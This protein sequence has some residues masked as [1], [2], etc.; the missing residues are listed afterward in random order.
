MKS[1]FN[2]LYILFLIFVLFLSSCGNDSSKQ[3]KISSVQTIIVND[4]SV[5]NTILTLFP[6]KITS[7]VNAKFS[8]N[9]NEEGVI[10]QCS[11]DG[12]NWYYCSSPVKYYR[13]NEKSHKFKVRAV[14]IAGNIDSTPSEYSWIID[15][16][17]P[18]TDI[19]IS[20]FPKYI[21]EDIIPINFSK[22]NTSVTYRCKIDDGEWYLCK[23]F[24]DVSLIS[25]GT[26][27]LEICAEDKLGNSDP[28]PKVIDFNIDRT[29]P[30]TIISSSKYISNS[31]DMYFQMISNEYPVVYKCQ[32][33]NNETENCNETISYSN[34]KEG[35]H[36]FK[37]WTTDLYGNTD[38]MPTEFNWIVDTVSPIITLLNYPDNITDFNNAVFSFT[39]TNEEVNFYAKID[40]D[41][42]REYPSV[43]TFNNIS[44]GEHLFYLYAIDKA[45]NSSEI[46]SYRWTVNE[47][48]MDTFILDTPVNPYNRTFAVFKFSSSIQNTDFECKFDTGIWEVCNSPKFY[49]Q[50]LEGEHNFQVRAIYQ[51]NIDTSPSQYTWIVDLTPPE[52]T[53]TGKPDNPSNSSSTEFIFSSNE[54]DSTFQCKLDSDNWSSCI[55]PKNYIGLGEGEH[56]FQ[57]KATDLAGNIDTSPSQYIWIVD[58]TPPDT[59]ITGTPDNLTNSTSADFTFSSNELDSTFQ[60]KL[61]SDN[62]SSCTS[63]KNYT[64]LN[65]GEHIFQ[66]R[67]IDIS[68]NIDTSP[69]QYTWIVDLTPPATT[70][71]S[72]PENPTNKTFGTVEFISSE[73]DSSFKCKLNADN[74]SSCTSPKNYVGLGEG[75]HVFQVKA[76]DLAG[77]TDNSPSQYTW[78][79][80][81]TPP[82]TAITG[83]PDNPT[84]STSADFLFSSNEV[85]SSFQCKL[86]SNNWS[87]CTSPKNY[88]GL[89]EGE[90][91]FQVKA[92]DLAGNTDPSPVQYTWTIDLTLPQVYIDSY[93]HNPTDYKTAVFQFHGSDDIEIS[94]FE[95]KL[96]NG[97]WSICDISENY[98]GLTSGNHTFYIKVYDT[99]GNVGVNEYTWRVFSWVDISVGNLFSCGI[100]DDDSLWCWGK[101]NHGQL[102]IGNS[103]EKHIATRVGSDTWKD[104]DCGGYYKFGANQDHLG[105]ACAIRKSDN[106]VFCWG[107][108]NYGQIGDNSDDGNNDQYYP[109]GVKIW[110]LSWGYL[111]ADY[112][113]S[114]GFHSCAIVS[115]GTV[116]CWGRND[117]GQLGISNTNDYSYAVQ[118]VGNDWVY[119]STGRLHSC[120]LKSDNSLWCWGSNSYGQLGDGS[121]SN[122]DEPLNVSSNNVWVTNIASGAV[123][124]CGKPGFVARCWGENSAG[125]LGNGNN[126]NYIDSDTAVNILGTGYTGISFDILSA[127]MTT[128]CGIDNTD[129]YCWGNNEYGQIGNNS[130]TNSNSPVHI[131]GSW[132]KISSGN[133]STCGINTDGTLYCWGHN[134]YGEL[135]DGT[136]T[137]KNIPTHVTPTSW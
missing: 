43:I 70:I 61:D 74:W 19:D 66:V 57:V 81:L 96:D 107:S 120:G 103:L 109:S 41:G 64:G 26:H 45:G 87:S 108:D 48:F 30:K 110:L 88:T 124:S 121:V 126:N 106:R 1:E 38:Y 119:I 23:D 113:F 67:A 131:S 25:E 22:N 82:E 46:K 18:E 6:D 52:T 53:I 73:A 59:T 56:V 77:N 115:T 15:I 63:S 112:I 76:T 28:T 134:S 132:S 58:L 3:E 47:I 137:E 37:V 90:H 116:Y 130:T 11:L 39:V 31:D 75:E 135:G 12:D 122:S 7:S 128:V 65:E 24:I 136:V 40:S 36:I 83:T 55:S 20:N 68:G 114:G 93:P 29:P 98:S 5:P 101:N 35:K 84:N 95:C 49:T 117:Y 21:T 111:T 97:N 91:V 34:L 94:Y 118:L 125:N 27:I 86:D 14:D 16:S 92:T 2:L 105:H 69:A 42:W 10:F 104:V 51:G 72:I 4:K 85:G 60:C 99:A 13:L 50:L 8:F 133:Y 71:T 123:M 127:S 80:D 102:G 100:R 54:L 62:W 44:V 89:V 17:S 129:L 32:L 79:V 9:S 78:I 33:D